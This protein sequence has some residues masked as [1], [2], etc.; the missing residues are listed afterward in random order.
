MPV[1]RTIFSKLLN[2]TE[3]LYLLLVGLSFFLLFLS[4]TGEAHTVWKALHP[5]F[6]PTL[7][8]ATFLLLLILF[9]SE[10]VGYRLLFV[11]SYSILIHSFFSIVFPA[12]D[13]S[14]QQSVLGQT[15]RVF[16]NSI[17]HGLSG[18]PTKAIGP[19]ILG[20]FNGTNLQAALSTIFARMLSIDIFYVHLFLVPVLWGVF[21]PIASFLT[22]KA[23]GA[24]EKAALLSSLIISAFPYTV[25]FGAISVPN[26]LGFIFFFYSL[27][28]MLRYLS[29]GNSR[30]AYATVAFSF[31]SLLS[32]YLTGLMSFSLLLLTMAL[33]VYKSEKKT[34][35]TN[36]R[37]L[38]T[39]SFLISGSLLPLSFICLKYFGASSHPAF[40]LGK[41][42]ELSSQQV[43]G[44]FLIGDLTFSYDFST[45]LLNVI[46]PLIALA[47]MTYLLVRLK[48]DP[49]T[50]SRP[51]IHL[52]LAAF[53]IILINYGVLKV[54]MEGLPLNPERLWVLRDFT[55]APFAGFAVYLVVSSLQNLVRAI[56]PKAIHF[57][58]LKAMSKKNV[59]C[60]FSL[61]LAVNVL[62]PA[63]MGGW[64]MISLTAAY[65]Q[66]A[67]LQT[68]SYELEAVKYI[69]ANEREKYVVIG[70]VWTIYAGE[71]IVGINNPRAYFF[72][73]FNTTGYDLFFNM[74]HNPSSQWMLVAMDYTNTSAAYFI[75]TE[76]RLGAVGFNEIVANTEHVLP[77]YHVAGEG[78]LY[79]FSYRKG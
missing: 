29:S 27:Y 60:I 42:Y 17:L 30:T 11:I 20:I 76:P 15:R 59:L 66:V 35:S 26:S 22:A 73:E 61:I 18:W 37:L 52:L 6:L 34:S 63:L 75:V 13:L 31:F 14:G 28:F 2:I 47:G 69:E 3:I 16:D 70:D 32:H 33:R 5:A 79:I 55:A 25:Y 9:A 43:I 77:V 51:Q 54:F 58:D 40:S 21:V 19:F 62:I 23:I 10:N 68:T 7:F 50:M 24:N 53:L 4:R 48:R 64:M 49:N 41:L 78:K 67:P 57:S 36:A 12:G 39:L 38:L 44:L 46:G 45:V 1:D 56:S 71:M 72:S 8:V 74:T 65:P